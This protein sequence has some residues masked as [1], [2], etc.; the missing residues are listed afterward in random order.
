M[1]YTYLKQMLMMHNEIF[2]YINFMLGM[3]EGSS[4][5]YVQGLKYHNMLEFS[6]L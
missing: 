5:L 3:G 6:Q 4:S 2:Y 1:Q